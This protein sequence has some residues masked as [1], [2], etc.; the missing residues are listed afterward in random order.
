MEEQAKDA[1][2]AV[3]ALEVK[4]QQLLW[5][6]TQEEAVSVI[7]GASRSEGETTRTNSRG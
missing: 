2:D 3:E 4:A 5:E 6:Q 7:T 1:A